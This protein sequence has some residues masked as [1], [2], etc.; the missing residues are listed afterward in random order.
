[1]SKLHHDNSEK[2]HVLINVCVEN[3]K[4]MGAK[5]KE[6]DERERKR[7]CVVLFIYAASAAVFMLHSP[8]RR[9]DTDTSLWPC[10][11]CFLYPPLHSFFIVFS[12]SFCPRFAHNLTADYT[13]CAAYFWAMCR[14]WRVRMSETINIMH[15]VINRVAQVALIVSHKLKLRGGGKQQRRRNNKRARAKPQKACC[16]FC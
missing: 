1:M 14:G 2:Y 12:L 11:S 3:W 8:K 15:D 16:D 10:A 9:G 5:S 6:R 7:E 13:N 4:R